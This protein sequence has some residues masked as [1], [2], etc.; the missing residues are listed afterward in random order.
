MDPV[1][2]AEA[3]PGSW[4]AGLESDACPSP[5][6]SILLLVPSLQGPLL[7]DPSHT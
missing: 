2:Q 7:W 4:G 5:F 3:G 1:E 6:C